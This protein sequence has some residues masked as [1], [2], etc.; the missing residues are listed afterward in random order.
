MKYAITRDISP[1]IAACEL[2]HLQ[3][4]PIDLDRARQQHETY[5]NVLGELGWTT[6][7]LPAA[8]E[9]ADSVFVEDMAVV[10]DTVAVLASP[11]A[12]SRR[13]EVAAVAEI[14]GRFRNTVDIQLPATL[15]GGDVLCL[16]RQVWVGV[17]DRTNQQGFEA[18]RAALEPVGYSVR[19]ASPRGCLHLKSAV[20]RAGENC[21]MVNRDWIDPGI[22]SGWKVLEVDPRERFA[23]NVLW[24]GEVTLVAEAY[25]HTRRRLEAAG[26]ACRAVD[27][28]ELAKAEGALTCCSVLF[29]A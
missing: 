27:M 5:C 11:G 12:V 9:L 22:F 24:L 28:S 1:R 15:D 16:D 25:P 4:T 20:T 8:A 21:L 26:V 17:G 7:R 3:R 23:A 18:L 13:P 6:I 29:E 19:S 14:L 2:S 10:T